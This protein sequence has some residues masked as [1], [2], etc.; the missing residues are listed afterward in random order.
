MV[1]GVSIRVF[2][3]VKPSAAG[4]RE[5]ERGGGEGEGGRERGGGG[6]GEREGGRWIDSGF[7]GSVHEL[8]LMEGCI[9]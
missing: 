3:E 1:G 7:C 9:C 4:E 6:G 2:T 8:Q 5:R